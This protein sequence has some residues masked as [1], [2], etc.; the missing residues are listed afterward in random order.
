MYQVKN[1]RRLAR[2][3]V[4]HVCARPAIIVDLCDAAAFIDM[5]GDRT[6]LWV[7]AETAVKYADHNPAILNPP[8]PN[9]SLRSAFRF[10]GVVWSLSGLS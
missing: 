9:F 1:N 5:H 3:L 7:T 8:L 4:A 2:Q 10:R 6:R